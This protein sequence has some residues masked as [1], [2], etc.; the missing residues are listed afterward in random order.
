METVRSGDILT[1][2]GLKR[3]GLDPET[4]VR[5]AY[6]LCTHPW[7]RGKAIVENLR[8]DVDYDDEAVYTAINVPAQSSYLRAAWRK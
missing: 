6:N 2:R 4:R 8:I 5:A 1:M 3:F 7:G